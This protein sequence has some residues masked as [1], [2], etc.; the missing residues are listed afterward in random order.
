MEKKVIK[1]WSDLF[2]TEITLTIDE[3]LNKIDEKAASE[4]KLQI[5]NEQLAKVKDF[6]PKR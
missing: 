6:L 4:K 5:A 1:H 2:K 3:R